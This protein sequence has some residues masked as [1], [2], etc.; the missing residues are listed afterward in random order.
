MDR[1]GDIIKEGN[2]FTFPTSLDIFLDPARTLASKQ[3]STFSVKQGKVLYLRVAET[4]D[5]SLF[6]FVTHTC[7]STPSKDAQDS[8]SDTFWKDKCPSDETVKFKNKTNDSPNFDLQ[9]K[10]FYFTGKK[11]SSVTFHC[12]VFICFQSDSTDPDCIQP[13]TEDCNGKGTRRKRREVGSAEKGDEGAIEVRTISSE[14]SILIPEGEFV[15]PDCPR[16]SVYDRQAKRCAHD[17]VMEV[18]GVYLDLPWNPRYSDLTS[19][20][21]KDMA[22]EKAY[23]LFTLIQFQQVDN[24]ILGVRVVN[25]G[26]GSIILDVQITYKPTI[27]SAQAFEIFKRAI[28]EP[29]AAGNRLVKILEIRREKVIEYIDVESIGSDENH[30]KALIAVAVV[31]IFGITFI[32]GIV[33]L[34]LLQTRKRRA[35]ADS[36]PQ[37]K[38]IVNLALENV[39]Y[40]QEIDADIESSANSAY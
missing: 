5:N 6:R 7:W 14:Q 16:N 29:I 9:L 19:I 40:H 38:N 28:Q 1:T 32:A 27:S 35:A 37:V 11:N 25:A 21:F 13:S 22:A 4:S 36:A 15:V 17:N 3:N 23:K 31:I 2:N 39:A 24:E 12:D 20:E 26:K 30:E 34:K 8:M 18:R 10:S 33:G